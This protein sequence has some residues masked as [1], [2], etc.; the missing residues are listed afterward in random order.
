[1]I[2]VMLKVKADVYTFY[3][4]HLDAVVLLSSP[5]IP[6]RV[7]SLSVEGLSG[8]RLLLNLPLLSPS[9]SPMSVPVPLFVALSLVVNAANTPVI[10]V[11]FGSIIQHFQR[12]G[13]PA[14][15][16]TNSDNGYA[17]TVYESSPM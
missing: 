8:L 15:R 10:T 7:R 3:I 11:A 17:V 6:C 9:A 2:I 1:V 4:R 5:L 12:P 13:S 14:F 16:S